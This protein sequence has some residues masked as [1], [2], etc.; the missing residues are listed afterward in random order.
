MG[1]TWDAALDDADSSPDSSE[2]S[3]TDQDSSADSAA[4]RD[5]AADEDSSP[6]G[7]HDLGETGIDCGDARSPCP[8]NSTPATLLAVNATITGGYNDGGTGVVLD[9]FPSSL[10]WSSVNMSGNTTATVTYG[11]GQPAGDTLQVTFNGTN[12]GTAI[13]IGHT[14][15]WNTFT[16]GYTTFAAQSGSGTLCLKAGTYGGAWVAKVS[17]L[18]VGAS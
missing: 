2:H 11:N 15:G 16:T 4:A 10:C 5:S 7:M 6:D 9:T 14:G 18:T 3:S 13:P 1:D 17:Q 12:I 8:T